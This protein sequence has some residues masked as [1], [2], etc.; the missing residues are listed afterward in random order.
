M[1]LCN[2]FLRRGLVGSSKQEVSKGTQQTHNVLTTSLQCRDVETTLLRCCVFAGILLSLL[3][4]AENV[5]SIS[6][7]RN[8]VLLN[9]FVT[10]IVGVAAVA[11]AV[12]TK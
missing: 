6:N 5:P 9:S 10:V 2:T 12:L 8:N 1:L 4:L 7:L 3:T 11:A